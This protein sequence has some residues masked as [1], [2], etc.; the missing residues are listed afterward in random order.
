MGQK[1]AILEEKSVI[2]AI[3]R[4]FQIKSVKSRDEVT[5]HHEIISRPKGGMQLYFEDRI[6]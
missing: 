6:K 3:L 2:S 1:F 5:I 4:R